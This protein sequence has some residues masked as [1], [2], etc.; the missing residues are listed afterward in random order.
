MLL[1]VIVLLNPV[2][3]YSKNSLSSWV[4]KVI[5]GTCNL[6]SVIL[7]VA[8]VGPFVSGFAQWSPCAGAAA[9]VVISF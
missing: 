7:K 3:S 5:T 8:F 1:L 6:V 4:D 2:F 9:W